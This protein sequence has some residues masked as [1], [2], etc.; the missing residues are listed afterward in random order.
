MPSA[1]SSTERL[2]RLRL[3][4]SENVGPV[5]FHQLL[6]RYGSASDAL[7]ALPEL[8][9]RGGRK[10]AIRIA[11]KAA[12]ERETDALEKVGGR[13]LIWG[14]PEFP[15]LLAAVDPAPPV[16]AVR[17]HPHILTEQA[18]AMVGARNASASGTRLAGTLAR[19][20]GKAGFVIVSGLARGIDAAAHRAALDTGTAA[21][22][23]GGLDII[24]PEQ[25][26]DIYEAIG[27]RGVLVSEMPLGTQP[28]ARHFPRRNRLISGLARAVIVV[29]AALRSGSLITARFAAEQNREVLAVP[30]SPLDPR[31]RGANGLI[32]QGAALIE[33]ADDVL[34]ALELQSAPQGTPMAE[35]DTPDYR[36]VDGPPPAEPDDADRQRIVECLSVTPTEIDE[37]VRQTGLSVATVKI[38]VLELDLAGRIERDLGQKVSLIDPGE[39]S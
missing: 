23:G 6:A 19:D 1:L 28:Q 20:L 3:A 5:T 33:N 38:V 34:M 17:G 9:A 36:S 22:L 25:N 8:A 10:R 35:P 24:Y 32:K 31:A 14:D 7:N 37:I 2:D 26:A 39:A 11:T 21:V 12:A 29:E 30:G 18:L 16:I 15:A 13:F 27:D 4:R